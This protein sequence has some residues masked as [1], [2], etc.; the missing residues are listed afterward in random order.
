MGSNTL[1]A[2]PHGTVIATECTT[3]D[4]YSTGTAS[5]QDG[6]IMSTL[7]CIPT[8]HSDFSFASLASGLVSVF[9]VDLGG[10]NVVTTSQSSAYD[11]YNDCTPRGSVKFWQF[12]SADGSCACKSSQQSKPV[13]AV[14]TL[15]AGPITGN[16]ITFIPDASTRAV[17]CAPG[18]SVTGSQTCTT[19][20]W[21]GSSASCMYASAIL[22]TLRARIDCF[23][24]GS[25]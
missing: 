15:T 14:S 2:I 18:Y 17:V 12:N 20:A 7:S 6:T 9:G 8:C 25:S 5:C 3:A 19:T 23:V 4:W 21:T 24:L 10:T 1:S 13:T 11:C 16:T 22:S